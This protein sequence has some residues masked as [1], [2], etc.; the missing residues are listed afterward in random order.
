MTSWLFRTI[1]NTYRSSL[2]MLFLDAFASLRIVEVSQRI[3]SAF[4]VGRVHTAA[5][6]LQII[7]FIGRVLKVTEKLFTL[8]GIYVAL[9]VGL[10]S[11]TFGTHQQGLYTTTTRQ[12]HPI[13][14]IVFGV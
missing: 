11:L 13:H 1:L 5:L 6:I 3:I 10:G 4:S 8:A 7:S 14:W 2:V 12:V 9:C